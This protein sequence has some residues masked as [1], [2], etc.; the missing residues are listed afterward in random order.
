[1]SSGRAKYLASILNRCGGR[2]ASEEGERIKGEA[3]SNGNGSAWE[4]RAK[5]DGEKKRVEFNENGSLWN[6]SPIL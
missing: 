1:M 5:R 6:K 2:L 3:K 4:Q